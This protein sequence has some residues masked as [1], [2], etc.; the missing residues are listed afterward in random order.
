[1]RLR[2]H[3]DW[4]Q[5]KK[6]DRQK[7]CRAI[8]KA[9]EAGLHKTTHIFQDNQIQVSACRNKSTRCIS[10]TR[11]C[12]HWRLKPES[13]AN[14]YLRRNLQEKGES[15]FQYLDTYMAEN[16]QSTLARPWLEECRK[17]IWKAAIQG[18]GTDLS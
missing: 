8:W 3:I 11:D 13:L 7:R 15:S 12:I 18:R 10:R 2:C 5:C 9:G 17:H 4:V 14:N 16:Q 6:L 1:M